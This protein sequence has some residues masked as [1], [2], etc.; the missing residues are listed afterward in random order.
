MGYLSYRNNSQ[1]VLEM[2]LTVEIEG[3]EIVWP[4]AAKDGKKFVF[5]IKPG[6]LKLVQFRR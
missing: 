2:E 1:V 5:V 6:F 4:S 3:A